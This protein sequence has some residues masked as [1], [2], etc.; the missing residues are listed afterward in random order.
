VAAGAVVS[1]GALTENVSNL[2]LINATQV[3]YTKMDEITMT[4]DTFLE[5]IVSDIQATSDYFSQSALTIEKINEINPYF[6]IDKVKTF[7]SQ[8]YY[9]PSGNENLFEYYKYVNSEGKINTFGVSISPFMSAGNNKT[10]FHVCKTESQNS[11]TIGSNI[12]STTIDGK[13]SRKQ[14]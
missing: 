11:I 12:G 8:P 4:L 2:L 10:L 9:L 7:N 14:F 6:G 1:I 5:D 13:L 3:N